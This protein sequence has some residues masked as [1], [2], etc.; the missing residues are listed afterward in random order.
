MLE[1]LK[2]QEIEGQGFSLAVITF[3]QGKIRAA[4]L[5]PFLRAE[6][7]TGYKKSEAC[8]T[9]SEGH[10]KVGTRDT[11]VQTLNDRDS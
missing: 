5:L 4:A 10:K 6:P 8:V 11:Q 2:G 7:I 9:V 1:M 3:R